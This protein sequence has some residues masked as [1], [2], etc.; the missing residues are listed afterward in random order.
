LR[1]AF[2]GLESTANGIVIGYRDHVEV[3]EFQHPVEE[4][5]H[6]DYTVTVTSVQVQ[7]RRPE[8]LNDAFA[9]YKI[10]SFRLRLQ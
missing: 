6:R 10:T 9:D 8:F 3:A 5:I 1:R 4:L 2:S 7:V